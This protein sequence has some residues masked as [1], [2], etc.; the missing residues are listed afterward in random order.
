MDNRLQYPN[1]NTT[2]PPPSLE[3]ERQKVKSQPVTVR[4]TC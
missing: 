3:I 2:A 1:K 4:K